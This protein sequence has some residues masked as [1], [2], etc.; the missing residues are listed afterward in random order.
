MTLRKG[1]V[2]VALSLLCSSSVLA[3][4]PQSQNGS[5]SCRQ[6]VRN[7]YSWYLASASKATQEKAGDVAIERRSYVFST[8]ILQ[9]LRED[10]EAQDKAG[11]DLV[12]LDGDPFVGGDGLSEDYVVGRVTIKGTRCWA[13]VHAVWGGKVDRTPDVT[14]ELIMK[15]DRWLFVNFYFPTDSDPKGWNLLTAL[16]ALRRGE[17]QSI[18]ETPRK[19]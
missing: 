10:K 18:P 13:E 19:P 12:S 7:F 6:F 16:Q 17:K 3:Q 11:S 9:A 5:S 1:I 4:E 8:A 15:N 2:V 14:A